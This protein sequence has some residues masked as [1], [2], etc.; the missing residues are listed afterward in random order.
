MIFLSTCTPIKHPNKTPFM[1]NLNPKCDPKKKK[2]AKISNFK[3]K[4][5]LK[6]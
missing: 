2:I 5:R 6:K 4:M 3:M 1:K